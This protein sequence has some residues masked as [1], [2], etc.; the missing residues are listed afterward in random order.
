MK[1]QEHQ[2]DTCY[3]LTILACLRARL[4]ANV[5]RSS[6]DAVRVRPTR[7]LKTDNSRSLGVGF[8]WLPVAGS[9]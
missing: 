2:F 5:C 8:A 9:T 3:Q 6:A 1:D 7:P 4:L